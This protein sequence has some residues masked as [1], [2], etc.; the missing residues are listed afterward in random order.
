MFKLIISFAVCLVLGAC[1]SEEAEKPPGEYFKNTPDLTGKSL[2]LKNT[3]E[4]MDFRVSPEGHKLL[5]SILDKEPDSVSS[6]A[7]P[8]FPSLT[9][10]INGSRYQI[11]PDELVYL[12][13]PSGVWKHL[14]LRK[15]LLSQST[16]IESQ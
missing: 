10:E 6:I 2:V 15:K 4:H 9:L 11:Q 16:L 5:Q 8:I 1:K 14:G 3:V 7:I 12:G 13:P